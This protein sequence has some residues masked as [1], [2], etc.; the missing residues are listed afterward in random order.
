MVARSVMLRLRLVRILSVAM[1]GACE[2]TG[3]APQPIRTDSLGVELIDY[4][5]SFVDVPRQ[6]WTT[7]PEPVLSIGGPSSEL[8]RVGSVLFQ[9]DGE[10]V[11]ANG[12]L[13]QL[14]LFDRAGTLR[15]RAGGEGS[16]PGELRELTDLSVGPGDSLFVYDAFQRRLSVFDQDATFVR[17]IALHGFDTLGIAEGVV[18]ARN[19]AII[20]AFRRRTLG[21]GLVR[22][23]LR[24]VAFGPSGEPLQVL[25]CFPHVYEHWGPHPGPGGAGNATFP[26]P[27]PFSGLT[28][29]GVGDSAVYVAIPDPYMVIRLGRNGPQ[30]ITR[31]ITPTREI[32]DMDRE[33]L[34]AS[35]GLARLHSTEVETLRNLRSLSRVPAFGFEPLTAR[36]G[37]RA[38]LIT[39]VGGVWLR[40]FSL[41]EDANGKAWPRFDADGFHEGWV[42]MPPRFRPTAVRGDVLIGVYRDTTDVEYIQGY[43]V[44]LN[45]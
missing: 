35:P 39:D 34:F 33:R 17:A 20:A 28:E 36:V 23:S 40:P 22:D 9:S 45:Q 42:L 12:G 5:R 27:V 11:A 4:T 31:Q 32:T 24:V 3:E 13:R 25:G 14:L 38:L 37:E 2:R 43:R 26:L 19:G 16:G 29:V 7:N 18:V 41:P 10:I 30:R 21:T 44:V 8:Y 1:L 6:T 15:A